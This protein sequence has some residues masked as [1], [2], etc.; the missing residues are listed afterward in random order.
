MAFE[1]IL[2]DLLPSHYR[3]EDVLRPSTSTYRIRQDDEV[4]ST[5]SNQLSAS[6]S[7]FCRKGYHHLQ[8]AY[9]S[10]LECSLFSERGYDDVFLLEVQGHS[11]PFDATGHYPILA[12]LNSE[13]ESE[14]LYAAVVFDDDADVDDRGAATLAKKRLA[15]AED[16]AREVCYVD[17]EGN[18]RATDRFFIMVLRYDP[19]ESAYRHRNIPRSATLQTGPTYW[20]K[21]GRTA[22]DDASDNCSTYGGESEDVDTDKK[23]GDELE[24]DDLDYEARENGV[25]AVLSSCMTLEEIQEKYEEVLRHYSLLALQMREVEGTLEELPEF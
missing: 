24:S 19:G 21:D 9:S 7:S 14:E 2:P 12:G 20:L 16:G 17:D 25:S 8:L 11:S 15:Y 4:I 10:E 1:S 23:N 13:D 22:V 5:A 3:R 18:L 6:G